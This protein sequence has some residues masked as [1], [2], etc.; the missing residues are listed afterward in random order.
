[1]EE[2]IFLILSKKKEATTD[3]MCRLTELFEESKVFDNGKS[4][5]NAYNKF[6]LSLT[7]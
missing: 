7:S 6:V 1:M 2:E 3:E 4:Y 5:L